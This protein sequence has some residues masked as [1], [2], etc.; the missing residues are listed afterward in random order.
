MNH[1]RCDECGGEFPMNETVKYLSATL[2]HGCAEKALSG[3]SEVPEGAVQLQVD[4]TVCRN[5]G[6]DS[7]SAPLETLVGLPVCGPCTQFFR[8]RPY[9]AWVKA[10]AVGLLGLVVF[11]LLFNARFFRAHREM[12]AAARA[13]AKPDMARAADLMESA[14]KRVP[15]SPDVKAMADFFRGLQLL[16]ADQSAEALS[17]LERARP[18]IPPEFRIDEAVRYARIGK[19]F[20]EED[21]DG[22]LREASELAERHPGDTMALGQLAS[23]YAC[24]YADTGDD[25]FK[26]EALAALEKARAAARDDPEFKEYEDRI[27]HR[28]ETREILRREEFNKRYPNGWHGGGQ[29]APGE[30]EEETR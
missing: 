30:Q 21:Y 2:C 4:P 12:K 20:D 5:C 7:G 15:E 17:Y 23:A 13:L 1:V 16:Q 27:L 29:Q 24:K 14:S 18:R 25:Q 6:F 3:V 11:A 19:C 22:F 28:I 10:A 26:Q 9:P 8:H